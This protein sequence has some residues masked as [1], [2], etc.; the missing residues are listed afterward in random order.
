MGKTTP[1]IELLEQ[2]KTGTMFQILRGQ[3]LFEEAIQAY[4]RGWLSV[5][6]S[7]QRITINKSSVS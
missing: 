1:M 7:S 6:E 4:Q 2:A 5:S 3:P